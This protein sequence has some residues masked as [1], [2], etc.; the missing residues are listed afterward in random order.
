MNC[1]MR[2]P[3]L[4]A[5]LRVRRDPAGVVVGGAC[6]QAGTQNPEQPR[7][8]RFDDS[9][10]TA[11]INRLFDF[12]GHG[13]PRKCSRLDKSCRAAA[14]LQYLNSGIAFNCSLV[15]L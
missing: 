13:R 5:S 14:R 10:L 11:E 9:A 3:E 15:A 8:G 1:G 6:D 2:V 7:F 4:R 12:E